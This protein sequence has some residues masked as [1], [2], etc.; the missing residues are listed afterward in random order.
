MLESGSLLCKVHC[1]RVDIFFSSNVIKA[2]QC[3]IALVSGKIMDAN[4]D[5]FLQK[6][7]EINMHVLAVRIRGVS[8]I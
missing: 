3:C 6:I 8:R 2:F 5:C 4:H 1:H 7:L